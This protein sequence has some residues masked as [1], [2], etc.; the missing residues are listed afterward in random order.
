MSP[1]LSY[2]REE[3]G[4]IRT[5]QCN[6]GWMGETNNTKILFLSRGRQGALSEL[7]LMATHH[8]FL[9]RIIGFQ[10][11]E[12]PRVIRRGPLEGTARERRDD[13]PQTASPLCWG[14]T[15]DEQ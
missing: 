1:G 4:E 9:L 3:A 12:P 15:E 7:L 14:R 13:H 6:M 5:D 11:R 10:R 2:E 8:T